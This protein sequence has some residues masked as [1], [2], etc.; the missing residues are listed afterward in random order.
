MT[1]L[2]FVLIVEVSR[3]SLF[4]HSIIFLSLVLSVT[5]VRHSVSIVQTK[6]PIEK[7]QSG[8]ISLSFLLS[9][10]AQVSPLQAALDYA[11]AL[12]SDA[13]SPVS[14]EK[15]SRAIS[16]LPTSCSGTR[17]TS[18]QCFAAPTAPT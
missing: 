10:S 16:F 14:M 1:A 13:A 18:S 8:F 3:V 6:N 11:L 17:L 9:L 5:A 4:T 12:A 7:G 15:I 2:G